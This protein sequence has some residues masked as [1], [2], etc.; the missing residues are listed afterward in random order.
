MTRSGECIVGLSSPFGTR[1]AL[2][3]NKSESEVRRSA[4]K[5]RLI[6]TVDAVNP[7]GQ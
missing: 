7:S 1:I 2:A 4:F 6:D 5:R 3:E